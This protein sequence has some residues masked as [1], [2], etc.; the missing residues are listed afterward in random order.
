MELDLLTIGLAVYALLAVIKAWRDKRP[1]LLPVMAAV[2]GSALGLLI[3]GWPQG[4]ILGLAAGAVAPL[5]LK[6]W[7]S[8]EQSSGEIEENGP[9]RARE[10]EEEGR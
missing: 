8:G 2:L 4:L 5:A 10:D 6:R 1:V 7:G 9:P 3:A